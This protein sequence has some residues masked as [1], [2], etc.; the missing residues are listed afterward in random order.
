MNLEINAHVYFLPTKKID[1]L[2]SHLEQME[3]EKMKKR[4]ELATS[5][6]VANSRDSEYNNVN[7]DNLEDIIGPQSFQ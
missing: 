2:F 4:Q 5:M 7:V 1:K 3:I 6:F